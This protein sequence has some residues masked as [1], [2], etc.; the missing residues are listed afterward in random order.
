MAY[1]IHWNQKPVDTNIDEEAADLNSGRPN[2]ITLQAGVPAEIFP[3]DG[4][5]KALL[6]WPCGADTIRIG[7]G[8]T[9][10]VNHPSLPSLLNLQGALAW[11]DSIS[12]LCATS[13]KIMVARS[14]E[15][16]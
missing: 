6:L 14:V 9:A 16:P 8:E 3:A 4:G 2:V 13:A 1:P 11:K 10:T 12:L 5:V 7:I 15:V